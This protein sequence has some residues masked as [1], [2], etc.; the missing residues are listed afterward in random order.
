MHSSTA[1]PNPIILLQTKLYPPKTGQQCI[2]RSRLLDQLNR[3]F[4]RKLTLITAPAGYGK[5]TLVS[6]WLALRATNLSQ[7]TATP[8]SVAWLSLDE[9]DNELHL[10]VRYLVAAIQTVWP[11]SCS[12]ILA[13]LQ[14]PQ[15]A[16]DAYLVNVLINDLID[17]PESLILVLDDYQFVK[18]ERIHQFLNRLLDHLPQSVHLVL[19]S[20]TEPPLS[21]PQ[22][23]VRRQLNELRVADLCFSD[24]E[25]RHYLTH[26]T[27]RTFAPE[28]V[29][30]LQEKNEGWIAG[31]YLATLSLHDHASEQALVR[32]LQAGNVNILDYLFTEV[33][34]KQPAAIQE[35]LLRTAILNRFCLP[36]CEALLDPAWQ[37]EIGQ[38]QQLAHIVGAS[39]RPVQNII[40]WLSRH[41]LFLIALDDAGEWYRY[42]HLFQLMLTQNL[43][44]RI[45]ADEIAALHRK[46][47]RWFAR[48]GLIDEAIQHAL[49]GN[50]PSYAIRLIEEQR[51]ALLA[52]FDYA[53]LERWLALLPEVAIEQSPKLLLLQCWIAV[54]LHRLTTASVRPLLQQVEAHLKEPAPAFDV[55]TIAILWAEVN[56]VRG[57]TCFLEH[58]FEQAGSYIQQAL[59]VLPDSYVF[60]RTLVILYLTISLQTKGKLAV[61]IALIQKE[62]QNKVARSSPAK[63]WMQTYL[64]GFDYLNGN[65]QRSV[66][67]A[68]SII[69]QIQERSSGS[70]FLLAVPYRWLGTSQYERND[71]ATAR[72]YLLQVDQSNSTPYFQSRLILAWIYELEGQTD[73]AQEVVEGVKLWVQ[74]LGTH[75]FDNEIASFQARRLFWQGKLDLALQAQRAV[76]IVVSKQGVFAVTEIPALTLV[77][78]LLAQESKSYWREAEDL[79]FGLWAL[80]EKV[81]S[82]PGK[83]EI[84]ALQALLYAR[85]AQHDESLSALERAVVLAKPGGFIRTFVDLGPRM[86]GLLYQLMVQGV[87]TDYLGRILAAF[88]QAIQDDELALQ[89]QQAAQA[90]LIE[91]LT[92]RESEI[93]LSLQK[94]LSNKAIARELDISALTVKR[95]SINL[96]QKLGVN[97][98]KQA[99]ARAKALG[100]LPADR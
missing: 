79:L 63:L 23:R 38:D 94:G 52:R 51:L 100:I 25:A 54:S 4:E 43:Q 16:A 30:A 7:V 3:G 67:S 78:I 39:Q 21:L 66:Q 50:E 44:K 8:T 87:V 14:N 68:Q 32:R 76:E 97:S 15:Q 24:T 65:L 86:A 9:Y 61:G 70:K 11:N 46:A 17:L 33:L 98:R 42:H 12:N 90:E 22:L 35:F 29:S 73:K 71:L 58:E 49:A 59:E 93:L 40:E 84:L 92:A 83:V 82:L 26:V 95:H 36:L 18:E 34:L 99:V 19:T 6:Q 45:S 80:A 72:H 55:D 77:K 37:K 5:T 64:A 48:E 57:A 56:A 27:G 2:E 74:L 89:V 1:P 81:H 69:H 62:A 20:R 60:M 53:T 85:Y 13:I 75:A 31:L 96:Y 91:P 28:T 47:G 10:F 41:H 88:P